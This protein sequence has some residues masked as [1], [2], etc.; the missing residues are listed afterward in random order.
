MAFTIALITG[1]T[2][3]HAQSTLTNSNFSPQ[4]GETFTTN[5][6]TVPANLSTGNGGANVTWDFHTLVATSQSS[7][8]FV[9]CSSTPECDSFPG[10]NLA[11]PNPGGPGYEYYSR[12]SSG[13]FDNGGYGSAGATYDSN[14][15]V[16]QYP[17]TYNTTFT[18]TPFVRY[19]GSGM[20]GLYEYGTRTCT[21]DGY[22]TL[23]L[24]SGTYQNALR[25]HW[26]E[27]MTDSA[28]NTTGPT[29]ITH[30][31][32]DSYYWYAP[33]FHST[34][35]IISYSTNTFI[36]TPDTAVYYFT[37]F[38]AGVSTVANQ[39]N[40]LNIYPNP[41]TGAFNIQFS[42]SERK[43]ITI[44]LYD[45]LGR[46]VA[47]IANSDYEAGDH[48]ISYNTSGL[49]KGVYMVSMK[50]DTQVWV[51]KLEVE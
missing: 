8:S 49:S 33:D 20:D 2:C 23:I 47:T 34:L 44:T 21:C 37:R 43:P 5:T 13:F 17:F 14:W 16:M 12:D 6:C 31:Q 35:L 26:V 45:M 22:G 10:S 42:L 15:L 48:N 7:G 32:F 50:S 18:N 4:P 27:Y 30:G 29:E 24:P 28:V 46:Q 41:T 39:Q 38:P 9:T 19:T 51:Q 36:T 1:T 40:S 11:A 25:A 3:L